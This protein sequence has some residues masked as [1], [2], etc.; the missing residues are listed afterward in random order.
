MIFYRR[1]DALLAGAA[2]MA[3]VAVAAGVLVALLRRRLSAARA[4]HRLVF[5]SAVDGILLLDEAGTILDFNP[6]A[7]RM[8]GYAASEVLGGDIQLLIPPP[9]H[10]A[11]RL[12]SSGIPVVGRRKSGET[13][14]IDLTSGQTRA[15]GRPLYI[16]VARDVTRLA[17]IQ[18]ELARA[19]DAAEAASH[20]KSAFL[21]SMSHE[22]RTPLNH[23]L[24]FSE[25]L[26]EEA[27]DG[28]HAAL[29]PDIRKIHDAGR[30]LLGMVEHVL[31]LTA[32][33]SASL[34]LRRQPIDPAALLAELADAARQAAADHGRE[35]RIVA[36]VAPQVSA[37]PERLRQALLLL[38]S[39]AAA[40]GPVTIALGSE[41]GGATFRI[42]GGTPPAGAPCDPTKPL[43]RLGRPAADAADLG[44]TLAAR[45]LTLMDGA[46]DIAA[47][48]VRFAVHLPAAR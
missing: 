27:E 19:R 16:G 32:I 37:D 3:P 12:L 24:G 36:G 4:M 33:E 40:A 10:A 9:S 8:F 34:T 26:L 20:A 43:A 44:L 46:L 13:F 18:D 2:L 15:A 25:L 30:Q 5:D 11:Y 6:A 31:D 1:R 41:G 23:I 17:R 38:V 39:R 29:T 42:A 47:D 35:L 14:P 45:L 7:E 28:G 48:G 21:L 22:L